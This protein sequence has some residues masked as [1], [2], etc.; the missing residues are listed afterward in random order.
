MDTLHRTELGRSGASVDSLLTV[1][2]RCEPLPT[3]VPP[4]LLDYD[5]F[6]TNHLVMSSLFTENHSDKPGKTERI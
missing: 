1:A 2:F 5:T 6:S 3:Q 4:M